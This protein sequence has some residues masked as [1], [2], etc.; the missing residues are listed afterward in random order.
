MAIVSTLTFI[1]RGDLREAF[2]ISELLLGDKHDLIHKAVGW[3]LREAGKQDS[4]ALIRFLKG[5]YSEMP[6]TALRYA[7]ERFPES[8]RRSM[9]RGNFQPLETPSL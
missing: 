6:R 8:V 1:R 7:T 4:R 5:H 9:L 3:M 2:G